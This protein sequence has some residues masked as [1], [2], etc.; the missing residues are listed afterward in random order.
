MK[1]R[2]KATG[3]IVEVM[4]VYDDKWQ[5]ERI[6]VCDTK[7]IKYSADELDFSETIGLTG[8][9]Y[10][11]ALG[12]KAEPIYPD[13]WEKLKHQYAG[14]ALSRLVEL[15]NHGYEYVYEEVA[16]LATNYATA[17]VEKLKSENNG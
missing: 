10:W 4:S 3:E 9:E 7:T 5:Y 11:E 13:Y 12:G 8:E 16:M 14:M 1:A 2:V 17:L 15:V 6:D